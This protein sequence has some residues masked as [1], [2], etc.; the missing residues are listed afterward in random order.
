MH[1]YDKMVATYK[2]VCS[3]MKEHFPVIPSKD[4]DKL[5]KAQRR[6]LAEEHMKDLCK[7]LGYAVPEKLM[8]ERSTAEHD[9]PR[10]TLRFELVGPESSDEDLPK[11][12]TTPG[13]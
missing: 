4:G 12:P 9:I 3:T 2:E 1:L 11:V 10:P 5:A 8:T 6:L 13:D 7:G